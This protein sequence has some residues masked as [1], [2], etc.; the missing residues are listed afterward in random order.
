MNITMYTEETASSWK[1]F[2]SPETQEDI[3]FAIHV[4]KGYVENDLLCYVTT[5]VGFLTFKATNGK[6]IKRMFKN[7][8]GL[9][10]VFG[11][12]ITNGI[13]ITL[14]HYAKSL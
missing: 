9:L 6:T 11:I 3:E 2:F 12:K 7:K 14:L 1:W 10:W 5:D 4:Q 13:Y 8:S